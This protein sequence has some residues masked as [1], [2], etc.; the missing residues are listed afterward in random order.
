MRVVID[1]EDEIVKCAKQIFTDSRDKMWDNVNISD[2]MS[3]FQKKYSEFGRT[4]PMVLRHIVQDRKFYEDVLRRFI[5]LNQTQPTHSIKEFQERQASYLAMVYR[6]EHKGCSAKEVARAKN[7]YVAQLEKEEKHMKDVMDT[8][9]KER[10]EKRVKFNEL[11][12][13]EILDIISRYSSQI[14]DD[15]EVEI[16]G[17]NPFDKSPTSDEQPAGIPDNNSV[18]QEIPSQPEPI[19]F[20][21]E[22]RT[23]GGI[24]TLPAAP[25]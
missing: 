6:K 17:E 9:Q 20:L 3:Q 4:F 24:R 12:R 15:I 10:E 11:K 8:V 21:P 5:R 16:G 14:P 2:K 13:H 22:A 19:V 18:S 25:K 23:G 1:T 7:M